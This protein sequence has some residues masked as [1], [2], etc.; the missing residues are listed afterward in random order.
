MLV[1]LQEITLIIRRLNRPGGEAKDIYV[2]T[3]MRR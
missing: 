2:R 3:A 1:P